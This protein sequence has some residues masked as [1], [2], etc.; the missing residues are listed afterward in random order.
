M[1]KILCYN[2]TGQVGGAERVLLTI[3][4]RLPPRFDTLL[5]CPEEGALRW[6]AREAGIATKTIGSL[7]A[8]FTWRIDRLVGYLLSFAQTILQLRRTVIEAHPDL[9]HANSVRAGLV[10]TVATI[11]LKQPVIWHVHDL[12]PRHPFNPFIRAVAYLSKR[13]RIVAVARASG[14]RL[15]GNLSGLRQRLSVIPNGID[16]GKFNLDSRGR[17]RTRRELQIAASARVIAMVARLTPSKGQLDLV[18]QF[19]Q[20]L[21]QFPDAKLL[22]VGAPAFNQ[23]HDYAAGLERAIHDFGLSECV[24]LL[25]ARDDVADIMRAADLLVVNS[26]SEACSLVI[27]E[28]MA[29]GTPVLATST[30]GTPEIIEHE[31]N[32]WLVPWQDR[33][34]MSEAIAKLLSQPALR[35]ELA[36]CARAR[37]ASFFHN[38]RFVVEIERLYEQT[39]AE[40]FLKLANRTQTELKTADLA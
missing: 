20:L 7:R 3:L 21:A 35:A 31:L 4:E 2:H 5:I 27:L 18:Q 17:T 10:A 32:G 16:A 30:G 29:C 24:Q 28:A 1:M 8:R 40:P 39:C 23:E 13:T 38:E 19:P 12:L 9:L 36:A 37:V 33:Q 15:V 11:G 25:G 26:A 6:L 14:D 22:I 34:A